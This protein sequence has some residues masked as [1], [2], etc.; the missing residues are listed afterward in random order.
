ME[1]V[2]GDKDVIGDSLP[3]SLVIVRGAITFYF[4]LRCVTAYVPPSV[5]SSQHPQKGSIISCRKG[6]KIMNITLNAL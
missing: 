1:L 6:A 2:L 3:V 5:P 4:G